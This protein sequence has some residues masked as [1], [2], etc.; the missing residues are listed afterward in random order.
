VAKDHVILARSE[1][2]VMAGF[3]SALGVENGLVKTS[4][5]AH[6]PERIYTAWTL[7]QDHREVPLRVLNATQS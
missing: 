5:Q 3:E 7:V 6:P 4:L 1:G 2:I